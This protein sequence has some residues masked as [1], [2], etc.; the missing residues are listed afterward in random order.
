M[1]RDDI[2]PH[3]DREITSTKRQKLDASVV[4]SKAPQKKKASSIFA[5]FRVRP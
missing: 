4:K 5:P 2:M 1:P 3:S